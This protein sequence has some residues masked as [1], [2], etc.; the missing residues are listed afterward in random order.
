MANAIE[1]TI[2]PEGPLLHLLDYFSTLQESYERLDSI[3][4]ND[5]VTYGDGED[6]FVSR[7]AY[8]SA[9][10]QYE[11]LSGIFSSNRGSSY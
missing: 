8:Y 7:D 3:F 6:G 9:L 5:A 11:V 10:W 1:N 2:V 4:G